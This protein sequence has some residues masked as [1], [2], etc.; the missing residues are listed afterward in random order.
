MKLFSLQGHLLKKKERENIK[1]NKCKKGK[2]NR[3]NYLIFFFITAYPFLPII[4]LEQYAQF[5]A[6][7]KT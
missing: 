7:L 3:L 4:S 2:K 1:K 5:D 6:I